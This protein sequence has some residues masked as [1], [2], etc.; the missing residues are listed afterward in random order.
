MKNKWYIV[1]TDQVNI[2]GGNE[3]FAVKKSGILE[4]YWHEIGSDYQNILLSAMTWKYWHVF[5][6]NWQ[7]F[8]S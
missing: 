2:E 4:I 3:N 5:V 1:M 6:T 8:V 7:K